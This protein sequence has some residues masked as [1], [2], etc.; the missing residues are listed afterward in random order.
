MTGSEKEIH[1][2]HHYYHSTGAG[3][4]KRTDSAG[5]GSPG[6]GALR[7]GSQ[8]VQAAWEPRKDLPGSLRSVSWGH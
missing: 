1:H 7:E 6:V 4:S 2:Y 3:I 5:H 8:K